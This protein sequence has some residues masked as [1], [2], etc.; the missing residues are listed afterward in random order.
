[1][2]IYGNLVLSPTLMLTNNQIRFIKSLQQR[3]HREESGLFV[4]EGVKMVE[5]LVSSD[6]TIENVYGTEQFSESHP[7]IA[8][9]SEYELISSKELGRIS[10]LKSSNQVLAVAK[11]RE[12][13]VAPDICSSQLCLALDEV[14]DPGNLGTILRLADWFGIEHVFCSENSVEVYN[15]KVVQSTMGSLF[16]TQI[17]YVDL[18]QFLAMCEAPVYGAIL[19]GDGLYEAD[20]QQNG[21]LVM[22]SE[23]H[24]IS[25]SIQAHLTHRI[26]IPGYG[27]AESLNVS[28]ATAVLLAEFRRR[29]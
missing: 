25:D 20:L 14:R 6:W 15:P 10:G 29:G 21:I 12:F 7:N 18:A 2:Q 1:M 5:E 16:R 17:H 19:G 23:S 4:V 13:E 27:K 3:K 24:G 11:K 28:T 8:K 9:I 22:G 26:T